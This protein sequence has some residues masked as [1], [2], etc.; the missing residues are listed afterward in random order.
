MAGNLGVLVAA[1]A[2]GFYLAFAL[3]TFA[4]Y[5]LI[6]HR[7]DPLAWR[8]A[9]VYM[10]LAVLGEALLLTALLLMVFALGQNPP[11][12]GL[13]P[14]LAGL[15]ER[16]WIVALTLAGFGIKMG[17]VPLHV[18]LALAHPVAPTPASAVL[19]GIIIKAGLVGW[20]RFLPL[21][22]AALPDWGLLCIGV[23]LVS[24][25]YGVLAGL[26]QARPKTVLAYS[27]ISQMG[28]VTTLIGIGLMAPGAW[29]MLLPMV[30]L[31]ALH[32]GL[33]KSALFLGVGVTEQAGRWAG[34]LLAAP[35]L[36][37]AGA[38]FTSGA[39]AKGLLKEAAHALP[40][41]M[42]ASLA[43]V[44]TASS[45]AT[46]LLVW[47][48]LYLAWPR[49]RSGVQA[50][51]LLPWLV[52]VLLG[53]ALP[54]W[55][56]MGRFPEQVAKALESKAL[57]AALWPV[58]GAGLAAFL[59]WE[60]PRLT[61]YRPRLPEGERPQALLRLGSGVL[62]WPPLTGPAAV[63]NPPPG[64][65]PWWRRWLSR[66]ESRAARLDIAGL[67]YLLLVLLLIVLLGQALPGP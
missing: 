18:W 67:W 41:F 47:R 22:G 44:Y 6:A 23:G 5:G 7:G 34:W 9:R 21:G 40:P 64:R 39:L 36:A 53:M 62:V 38:P 32:H 14:R 19:S 1:D 15:A 49:D 28:L 59:A 52:L 57:L 51:R 65:P 24:A 8:A 46:A 58:L 61:G 35:A 2:V 12:E 48:F 37:L 11:L 60:L 16:D 4:A 17:V 25:F 26:P 56:A 20:L 43:L 13:A 42:G 3:L 55:W 10:T 30:L 45:V 50:G 66:I 31:F 54:W 29:S 27:S 63:P 33:A